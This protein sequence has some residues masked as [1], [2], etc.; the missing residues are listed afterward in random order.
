MAH[1]KDWQNL[2]TVSKMGFIFWERFSLGSDSQA[3]GEKTEISLNCV[4][5][6]GSRT[7]PTRR[8]EEEME[9]GKPGRVW[10]ERK[11][12]TPH[13]SEEIRA[14]LI[15]NIIMTKKENKGCLR[16][17]RERGR[18]EETLGSVSANTSSWNILNKI[19]VW[20][21]KVRRQTFILFTIF[22]EELHH[23]RCSVDF[24][25]EEV[26]LLLSLQC[27][28]QRERC[29]TSSLFS[30]EQTPPSLPGQSASCLQYVVS[31]VWVKILTK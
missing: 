29:R 10:A 27:N 28:N 31:H 13:F 1:L 30:P 25:K 2:G 5:A 15:F 9:G 26:Q 22:H 12:H 7:T 17:R 20:R 19:N 4:S 16:N 6:G 24:K 11:T 3:A 23:H 18:V 8:E 21:L 14:M